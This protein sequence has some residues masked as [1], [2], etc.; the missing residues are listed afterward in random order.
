LTLLAT[1]LLGSLVGISSALLGLGGNILI[2]PILPLI[3]ELPLQSVI[4][5]GIFTVF[6]VTLTNVINFYRQGLLDFKI[7]F[8]LFIP[9]SV[10]SYMSSH[11]ATLIPENI[12]KI[13]FL[14]VMIAML[15]KLFLPKRENKKPQSF[16]LLLLIVGFF[17]GSLA[18]L[19][20]V[21]TGILLAPLLLS[22]GITDEKKVSPTINFLIMVS[23]FFSSLNY[24]S[25]ENLHYPNSGLVRIDYALAIALPAILSSILGRKMNS[26]ISPKKRRIIVGLT[27]IALILKTI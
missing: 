2:V 7:I 26:N 22:M 19:T 25:F 15:I 16:K 23:C 27:L 1:I 8:Y 13:L 5:T 12:I 6:I 3:S 24:L 17:S 4:A 11:Y 21:G 14:F 20:G 18:G 10:S 9:T